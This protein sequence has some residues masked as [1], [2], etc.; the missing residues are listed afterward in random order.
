MIR[1]SGGRGRLRP[2]D[3]KRS[4]SRPVDDVRRAAVA[5]RAVRLTSRGSTAPVT[6]CASPLRGRRGVG[7]RCRRRVPPEVRIVARSAVCYCPY[8][9]PPSG[10]VVPAVLGCTPVGRSTGSLGADATRRG[11]ACGMTVAVKEK[12]G[13]VFLV[14]KS[15]Q[16][17]RYRHGYY[18]SL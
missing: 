8:L 12:V 13:Y 10:A 6:W 5:S 4:R 7:P 15:C 1:N 9:G 3:C 2:S 14:G 17:G 16:E 18:R 11:I